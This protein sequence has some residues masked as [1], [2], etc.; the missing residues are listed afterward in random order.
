MCTGHTEKG[1]F[2]SGKLGKAGM[3]QWEMRKRG[4]HGTTAK[5][6]SVIY[7]DTYAFSWA[8]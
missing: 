1:A 6:L 7:E 8:F 5:G 2:H 3:L 4:Y